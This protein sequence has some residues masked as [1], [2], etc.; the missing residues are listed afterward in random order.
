MNDSALGSVV[1]TAT[2][3][4]KA[5]LLVVERPKRNEAVSGSAPIL[6][7][8]FALARAE[9]EE[10]LIEC[11]G[12]VV[13]AET[14]LYRDDLAKAY[15]E[16]PILAKSGFKC[17]LD[18]KLLAGLTVELASEGVPLRVTARD[19]NGHKES[20]ETLL[21]L[22]FGPAQG[23]GAGNA[24]A[25]PTLVLQVDDAAIDRRGLLHIKG[26]AV[27]HSPIK[28]VIVSFDSVVLGLAEL[29][30][31]RP[32]VAVAWP[33]FAS[34]AN[35]GFLF[36][37][38]V[39]SLL[40][41]SGTARNK[42]LKVVARTA[43]GTTRELSLVLR[44]PEDLK[45]RQQKET[46][47]FYCD[48][49]QLT[50][51]GVLSLVGWTLS[52]SEIDEIR[53]H[54]EGQALGSA[55]YGQD[56]PDV[57]NKFPSVAQSRKSGFS[58]RGT[59]D[60]SN[61]NGDHQVEIESVLRDGSVRTSQVSVT[62]TDVADPVQTGEDSAG[63]EILLNIDAPEIVDGKAQ[64]LIEGT[65]GINGWA[66]AKTGIASV[67]FEL[68]GQKVGQ[69]YYGVRREDVAK[70]FPAYGW[71]NALLSGF[72]FS[73]PH[74]LLTE[75]RHQITVRVKT[76]SDIE[77]IRNFEIEVGA[78]DEQPGPWSLRQRI[79]AA[80]LLLEEQV[81]S[82]LRFRPACYV[83]VSCRAEQLELLPETL[84]SIVGQS[85]LNWTVVIAC[86]A[87][88]KDAVDEIVRD[89]F[90]AFSSQ[91]RTRLASSEL[92]ELNAGVRAR[93]LVLPL[94]A[95]DVLA[96]DALYEFAVALNQ[97]EHI[98]FLYADE[99]RHNIGTEREDAF[100]KPN[101]SPTLLLASN[102]IGRPWCATA[103][104]FRNAKI[105]PFGGPISNFDS[106]LRLTEGAE[107]IV[108]VPHVLARRA[109]DYGETTDA[110]MRALKGALQRR[111]LAWTVEDGLIEH[112]YRCHPKKKI[113][114][115]VSIIIPTCASRGL[116]KTCLESLRRL[117]SYK[118]IE[119]ICIENI[120]DEDSE[121]KPW[122]RENCDVVVEIQE[123]FNWSLF[124]NIAAREASG[125]YLLFLNDDIEIIQPD[126][127]ETMLDL[128]RMDDV[129]VVGPQLLYPDRKVQHA[130][131]FLAGGSVA[132]HAF[133]FCEADDPGYFGLAL[134]QRD[135]IAVTG[136]CML[137]KT[138]TFERL[139]GF[140]E[141][142][143]V[144][145]N[146][147]DFCLKV[148]QEK[149]RCI[150]TPFARLIHHELA[151]RKDLKDDHDSTAF[152]AKWASFIATGDPFFHPALDTN[153]D[154]Y[155]IDL[156]ATETIFAGH[157]LFNRQ[158]AT[159]ILAVKLDHIGDFITAFP[160]F[161][162]IK[163]QFPGSE[164][165]V[166]VAP[167]SKN[168]AK[169]EPAIDRVVP[170]QFF[171]ARSQ[172]GQAE[173]TKDRLDELE[174]ELTPYGFDIA[175]D[176]RKQG[177]TRNL[178]K[179][180]GA[181]VLAG[182]DY[183]NQF[184]W[185]DISLVFEGDIQLVR[186]HQHV[187]DDLVS[188]VDTVAAAGSL[189]RVGICRP[190]DLA[191][192]QSALVP[193]LRKRGVYRRRLV[194]VHPASGNE[195]RQWPLERFAEISNALIASEDVDIALIGGP[196]E[197]DFAAG[198]ERHIQDRSRVHNLVGKFKLDELPYFLE[199]CALFIGNNSGP[200]HLAAGLGVPTVGIHSGVVDA[201][202]WGPLGPYAVAVQRNMA[203]S[204]CYFATPDQC[205][206][207]LACLNG[208]TAA[209]I[210]N[211]CRKFLRLERGL[212][213]N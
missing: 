116:I 30:Q 132:R 195:M 205:H 93:D 67:E 76:K 186:K 153:S 201:H 98:D 141:S 26:W 136:A 147:L 161:R 48:H 211:T 203:C 175:I 108:H 112:T 150:Y 42:D 151:S 113:D 63:D 169:L 35:G 96:A 159:R 138:E 27:S 11:A 61:I 104:R 102:Y 1:R 189:E 8:G 79:P 84:R 9:V 40:S 32:D 126:W 66:I 52:T 58:F 36:V 22:N 99:R 156:E 146:D 137:L 54:F 100:F 124:N 31:S 80:E 134:T 38:D 167:A 28:D 85:Y 88:I 181:K 72:A 155:Q 12:T 208:L 74:R 37:T 25:D 21:R 69:A 207:G 13:A 182:F 7:S 33:Q 133:R 176:L 17:E 204:P 39:A 95:G 82:G 110:E 10:V 120:L 20:S 200:K 57:G 185:L 87:K 68:D 190:S 178:L 212:Q 23:R 114:G 160:A 101:W 122:L 197:A 78:V 188:L 105:D 121:W 111:N 47:E 184:P 115:L 16:Y 206:R 149:L 53:V 130:G 196:D 173:I 117:S 29:A 172:L 144:I 60:P 177:D 193:G 73:L 191:S 24:S 202:E 70:A 83:C 6:V 128:A 123:Q 192:R 165:T 210:I 15:P 131:M 163:E 91:I 2:A 43:S 164:L 86:A 50:K 5:I 187:S 77:K 18:H 180:C 59:I 162:R 154:L 103:T 44:A 14:G 135:V 81:I 62:A 107:G 140:E 213:L 145:N 119:I 209:Q 170:F 3:E 55:Q 34:A 94:D 171:H 118:N 174:R 199:T 97:G 157:P 152:D 65:F 75:G 51:S 148:N 64:R 92:E 179:S 129:G 56:R 194:C 90:L 125:S 106:V 143:S 127:L 198:V 139:G 183:R 71:E 49:I 166:L 46:Y 4:P 142:H 45:P 41:D 158:A 19:R 168:L 89:Q 109:P